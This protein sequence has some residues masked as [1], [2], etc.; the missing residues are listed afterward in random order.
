M[1]HP[2]QRND[3]LK[4]GLRQLLP[5]AAPLA[6]TGL[7]M[8]ASDNVFI[9]YGALLESRFGL[10]VSAV[11]LASSVIAVAELIAEGSAASI[12]D[13]LGKRRVVLGG[14]LLN[15]VAYL[16]LPRLAGSLVG[17]LGGVAL[18]ILAFEF[19]VVS[20]LP[21]V[22]EAAPEARGTVMALNT[23]AMAAAR[24]VSSLTGPRLWA[25]GGLAFNAS[26]SA[27]VIV[28]ATAIVWWKIREKR[29]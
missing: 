17:A 9:V 1:H 7:L 21:L 18:M 10:A 13:R 23:A 29:T 14:L 5:A 12:V 27:A 4:R 19:S 26:V 3:R 2:A 16:L 6:V 25:A 11:G 8:F 28:F 24:V 20:L 22:S 15:F